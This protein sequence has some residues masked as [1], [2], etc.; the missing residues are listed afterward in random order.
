[1]S[2]NDEIQKDYELNVEINRL[3]KDMTLLSNQGAMPKVTVS[4]RDKGINL[5]SKQM[6]SAHTLHIDYT[7]FYDN[8]NGRL[9]L[10]ES[11]LNSN[12]R[13]MFGSASTI[14]SQSPDSLSISYTTLPPIRV[15]I[16]VKT[17]I[18]PKT[19]YIISGQVI[20][21][22]DSVLVY[23]APDFDSDISALSTEIVT[24]TNV[25]DTTTITAQIVKPAGCRTVPSDIKVTIPVE[26]LVTK[27]FEIQVE[28]VNIPDGLNIVTFPSTVKFTCLVPMSIYAT[29]SYPVKAYADYEKRQDNFIPL[30]L[31]ILPDNYHSGSI[32][33]M[34]VE[35]VLEQNDKN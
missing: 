17:R 14:V 23:M 18:T 4:V 24:L 25:S 22:T 9:S 31:S 10:T 1:M 16:I 5:L 20:P 30:E 26:P 27:S 21:S 15:P 8:N 11:Q 19:Q 32:S 3:P 2:L 29:A 6:L 13:Q 12:L 28:T 7:D 33:P 35:Y 34:N